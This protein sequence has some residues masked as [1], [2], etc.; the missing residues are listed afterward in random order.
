MSGNEGATALKIAN[1]G[2]A[3][4]VPVCEDEDNMLKADH[5]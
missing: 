2:H 3:G 4:L 5:V 1:E